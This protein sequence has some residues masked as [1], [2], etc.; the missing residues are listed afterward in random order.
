[1]DLARDE[2]TRVRN[3]G[4][5]ALEKAAKAGASK[6]GSNGISRTFAT[7]SR[8][9]GDGTIDVSMGDYTD[10]NG[11]TS[12]CILRGLRMTVACSSAQ[13][14]DRVIVD[15]YAHVSVVTGILANADNTHYVKILWQ[16]SIS[17]SGTASIPGIRSDRLIYIKLTSTG[18]LAPIVTS[19]KSQRFGVA[20]PQG[21]NYRFNGGY[22]RLDGESLIFSEVMYSTWRYNSLGQGPTC[23]AGDATSVTAIYG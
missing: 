22:V 19:D 21:L 1:M 4:R 15:T 16:G 17:L 12:E 14:G 9:N 10:V 23:V 13:V 2:E 11:V 7:V 5:L 8:V 6:A 20:E 18:T 3:L